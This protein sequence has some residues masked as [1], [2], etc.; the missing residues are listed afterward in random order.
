MIKATKVLIFILATVCSNGYSQ[1]NSFDLSDYKLPDLN[2]RTL[3]TYVNLSGNNEYDGVAKIGENKYHG[4]I[5]LNYQHYQNKSSFQR[6]T[7][8]KFDI[9]P[10]YSHQKNEYSRMGIDPSISYERYNRHYYEENKFLTTDI[11]FNYQYEKTKN[12][13]ANF[14]SAELKV[15]DDIKIHTLFF[16][17]PVKFGTGRI[18]PVQ[19]ARHAVYIYDRLSKI[20][21]VNSDKTDEEIKELAQLIS[22]LKNKRFFDSRLRRMAELETI[23]SFLIAKNYLKESDA[24][25]FTTLTDIWDYGN[26]PFR[27]SGTRVAGAFIPGYYYYNYYEPETAGSYPQSKQIVSSFSFDAGIELTREK[28]VNLFW[29]NSINLN[30]YAGIVF[31]NEENFGGTNKIQLPNIQFAFDQTFAYYPNTRT[32][33]SFGYVVQFVKLF[34]L[35]DNEDEYI[36]YEGHGLN[37]TGFLDL[38]YYISPRLRFNF[39][40]SIF[41]RWQEGNANINFGNIGGNYRID[42]SNNQFTDYPDKYLSHNFRISLRY[43]IF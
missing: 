22:Q 43:S 38:N 2:R 5:S 37:T 39:K 13:S 1:L 3:D 34:D 41:Y 32:D 10:Q 20:N 35:T 14:P 27:Y 18:E 28:P 31:V 30:S 7:N 33:I 21:R 25:Y 23:D 8:V 17:L 4:N 15:I 40:S 36:G 42:N 16:Q 26:R 19:D 12:K 24:K 6:L 29:Q 9:S 11:I